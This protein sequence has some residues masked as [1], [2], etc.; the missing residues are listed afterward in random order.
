MERSIIKVR[1]DKERIFILFDYDVNILNIL[2]SFK[3]KKFDKNTK[4]HSIP[5]SHRNWNKLYNE[6]PAKIKSHEFVYDNS[7]RDL[8]Y[9]FESIINKRAK[10]REFVDLLT[11]FK[12]KQ[13]PIDLPNHENYKKSRHHQLV[14]QLLF[15]K[16][17][18]AAFFS[19]MG[20]GKTKASIDC[21]DYLY[22]KNKVKKCLVICKLV[23]IKDTWQEQ[24]KEYS[25]YK[26][27]NL[28]T[29]FKDIKEEYKYHDNKANKTYGKKAQNI[30][31]KLSTFYID[32]L[33]TLKNIDGFHLI[34]FDI[35]AD[36]IDFL[37]YLDY[38]MIIVDE[39]HKIS[40]IKAQRTKATIEIGK[41]INNKIILTGTPRPNNVLSLF[42]QFLFLDNGETFGQDIFDFYQDYF[43]E[44]GKMFRKWWVPKKN[45]IEEIT[46]KIYPRSITYRTDEC[47]QLPELVMIN[48]NLD[49]TTE[50]KEE[51]NKLYESDIPENNYRMRLRTICSGFYYITDSESKE[52]IEISNNKLELLQDLI[53]EIL[54]QEGKVIVW[55]NFL[56]ESILISKMLDTLGLRYAV[57]NG[58]I[59]SQDKQDIEISRFKNSE[60]CN[61]LIASF[62]KG[63]ESLN[64]QCAQ[65]AIVY[66]LP[67]DFGFYSQALK[68]NHRDGCQ[69]H[70]RLFCYVFV[71]QDTIEEE[72]RNNLENKK[73]DHNFIFSY[74]V[75][76]YFYN[77]K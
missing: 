42:G 66:S 24:I 74:G 73:R 31:K 55:T 45:V 63:S 58:S 36:N 68:R 26:G 57:C 20:T 11:E 65:Y 50:Q 7:F 75:K 3:N 69:I 71:T 51:I 77:I 30:N 16:L 54:N 67:D 76:H 22:K 2:R 10:L 9:H 5:I 39:S 34:N 15:I 13:Y 49:L 14:M 43:V 35:V 12:V 19:D 33:D 4:E 37:Q 46:E 59:T 27:I 32:K 41:D 40:N 8:R 56:H 48:K 52:V 21:F 47:L 17:K 25:I 38:D 60:S 72:I 62:A 1:A 61:I 6:L 70:N 23:A 18:Q 28:R 53:E 64:L 44:V 29:I